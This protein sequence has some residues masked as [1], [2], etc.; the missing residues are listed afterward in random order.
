M[1]NVL[2][3]SSEIEGLV[4]T[5]GL[6]DV[7]RALPDE[8]LRQGHQVTVII[9][10]YQQIAQAVTAEIVLETELAIDGL[11]SIPYCVRK[12]TLGDEKLPVLLIDCEPYFNRE[13]IYTIHNHGYV[14][15]TERFMFFNSACLDAA[16]KL[17]LP[18]DIIHCNDWHAGFIPYLLKYRYL[19][20][21][22][23]THVRTLLTVHN[24]AFKGMCDKHEIKS[25]PEFFNHDHQGCMLDS[26]TFS[27]LKAGVTYANKVV[28]VSPSYAKELCTDLGSQ[29]MGADFSAKGDDLSGIINGC[30]YRAWSPEVDHYLPKKYQAK[31]QSMVQGKSIAKQHLCELIGLPNTSN[32]MFGMVCRL[33]NQKGLQY[34]LPIISMF[35][36]NDVQLVI[37]GTGDVNIAKQLTQLARIHNDKFIFI[38]AYDNKLAHLV[39]AASDIFLMPSEFEP[40][41]LNQMYSMAYGTVPLV[42]SVGGL[43]DTVIDYDCDPEHAT[44]FIFDL[45]EPLALLTSMQRALLLL[46]Q[47]KAAFRAI[48]L[49]GMTQRFS[50]KEATQAY[51]LLYN[52]LAV[53]QSKEKFE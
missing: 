24:A 25:C 31:N 36:V 2:F 51:L 32:P 29:G 37:V 39:E 12:V 38:E 48:Q 27:M 42:R 5:G 15:N 26:H 23:F 28:A 34:L 22:K 6:A 16:D 40:C 13:G 17:S 30:D 46:I 11:A 10:Y 19:P 7:A 50:W 45:P 49:R 44:G 20:Q 41:G 33:T 3:V 21:H 18:L 35:L 47:N 43:A 9:P 1:H 52:A 4:K 14:D 8:L 53:Q